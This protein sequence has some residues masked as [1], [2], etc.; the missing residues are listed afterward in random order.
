MFVVFNSMSGLNNM[1]L[2]NVNTRIIFNT[3][4]NNVQLN[5]DTKEQITKLVFIGRFDELKNVK[6]IALSMKYLLFEDIVLDIY[7]KGPD[8][9]SIEQA[10]IDNSLQNNK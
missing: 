1:N 5:K 8:L 7:G 3:P 4:L 9:K 6:N 2:K 10:I